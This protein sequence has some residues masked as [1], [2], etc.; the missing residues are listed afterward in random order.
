MNILRKIVPLK[1][2]LKYHFIR[3]S[4][5]HFN[6]TKY[7]DKR[8]IIYGSG[9]SGS[10]LL[11]NLLNSHPHIFCDGEILG[12][13]YA[14]NVIWP[15]QYLTAMSKKAIMKKKTVYGFKMKTDEL[16][17]QRYLDQE[18]LLNKMYNNGWKIIHL[19]R[20]NIVNIS[21][22]QLK[23]RYDKVWVLHQNDKYLNSKVNVNIKELN[24]LLIMKKKLHLLEDKCIKNI[25]HYKIIYEKDLLNEN[26]IKTLK[27][28]FE[29]LE[30]EDFPV[31]TNMK[32]KSSEKLSERIQNFSEVKQYLLKEGYQDYIGND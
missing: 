10:T 28:L 2:R 6:F 15:Y 4:L 20:N 16:R 1:I 19:R 8:F 31:S 30:I 27:N 29:H 9:R 22:S 14:P 11:T 25:P 13:R 7:P 17:F 24:E 3:R 21:L 18:K 26:W 12:K 32:K 5:W 23:A